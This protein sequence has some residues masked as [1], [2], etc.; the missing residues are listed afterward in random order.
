MSDNSQQ[1]DVEKVAK[2]ARIALT[3]EEK[4]KF[5]SQLSEILVFVSQL[6]EVDVSGVEPTAQVTGLEDVMRE[7]V[8]EGCEPDVR[9][10]LIKQ[11]PDSKDGMLK[12]P[13]VFE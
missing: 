11:M 10:N 1:L 5:Q 6:Q 3:K 2:L 13:A 9:D 7:D 12:V 4:E 8:V